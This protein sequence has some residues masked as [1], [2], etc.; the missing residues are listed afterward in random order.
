MTMGRIHK[1]ESFGLVDGP[2]VRFVVFL[3]GC[4]MRCRYCHN[5][6]TWK[7]SG[8]EEISPEA[9]FSKV[10]RYKSYWKNNGGVTVS[11]GEPLLQLDFLTEFFEIC[12]AHAVHTA[13]DTSGNPFQSLPE[14]LEKLDRLLRV[15]NLVLLDLKQFDAKAHQNLTGFSNENIL[16]FA[17]YLSEKEIP[18]WIRRVLVPGL[19]DL[20]EDLQKTGEFIRTLKT[21]ERIEVL[22]YH[23]FAL[24]KYEE[25]GISYSLKDAKAPTEEEVKN[26]EEKLGMKS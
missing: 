23:A 13:L 1:L 8:G 25:L 10:Y 9:L 17:K 20:P 5:P 21:V 11:G 2:G 15:T 22:P 26:A 24:P 7:I 18:L 3:Q 19:T 14:Y 12:R 4:R 6:E 16:Q